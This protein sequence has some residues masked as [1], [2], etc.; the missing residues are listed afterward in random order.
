ME[1]F[2]YNFGVGLGHARMRWFALPWARMGAIFRLAV[3]P[4]C[5][6][7]L[8]YVVP[9][10]LP[11]SGVRA[12][13]SI[14]WSLVHP[15]A[16]IVP[17]FDSVV[18]NTPALGPVS[19]LKL[20]VVLLCGAY[21]LYELVCTLASLAGREDD[22]RAWRARAIYHVLARSSVYTL[23]LSLALG[24]MFLNFFSSYTA[25]TTP[26]EQSAAIGE[27]I[28]CAGVTL[29]FWA[30]AVRGAVVLSQGNELFSR[31]F[32]LPLFYPL[33]AVFRFLHRHGGEETFAFWLALLTCQILVAGMSFLLFLLATTATLLL[34][35]LAGLYLFLKLLPFFI[36]LADIVTS[37]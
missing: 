32:S 36:I 28:I 29:V 16:D 14:L 25:A 22:A 27:W 24:C 19:G 18:R 33:C 37:D 31:L 1:T 10:L 12:L 23:T 26:A 7:A 11:T 20:A 30:I 8:F 9:F 13:G 4:A 6:V 35:L 21:L 17:L 34:V 5:A 2:W 3:I 15:D